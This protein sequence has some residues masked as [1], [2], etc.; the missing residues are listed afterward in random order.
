MNY[1][2]TLLTILLNGILFSQVSPQWSIEGKWRYG[3]M[4][5]HRGVMGHLAENHAQGVELIATKRASGSKQWH[6]D[7]KMP[8][9]K[10]HLYYG[11]VS[12][13][14]ILGNYGAIFTTINYPLFQTKNFRLNGFFGAGLGFSSKWY[15]PVKNPKNVAMS[16]PVF[17]MMNIGLNAQYTFNKNYITLGADLMHFSNG[18]TK[19][20]NLGINLPYLS[21][22]YGRTIT[23]RPTQTVDK[24]YSFPLKKIFYG[25]TAIGSVKQVYP[26]GGRYYGIYALNL[27]ARMIVKPKVGWEVNFDIISKQAIYGYRPEIE[28][29]QWKILQMG[30]YAGYIL[31]LDRF[32]YLV[33]VGV[34][35]KDF[36]FP[37]EH[38]YIRIGGR[39][40]FD[41]GLHAQLSLKTHYGKADYIE[42]GLGYSFNYRKK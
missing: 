7:Y 4:V 31:P 9:F 26:T 40:Y 18:G 34:Y 41:S 39:Y 20:P 36:Y 12:N 23:Q 10:I 30:I 8:D 38:V 13:R 17:A 35:V 29:T 19:I 25:V 21:I 27:H 37:D 14:K 2:L 33:G 16:T 22:S 42:L 11:N 3:F 28:K 1:H 6:H 15:D 5:G 24:E 32:Q